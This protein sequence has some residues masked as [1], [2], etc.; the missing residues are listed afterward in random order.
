MGLTIFRGIF[1]FRE[2][3]L[4]FAHVMS[5]SLDHKIMYSLSAIYGHWI[6]KQFSSPR[7]APLFFTFIVIVEITIQ[8]IEENAYNGQFSTK[9]Q[10]R[11]QLDRIH[12]PRYYG[13][14]RSS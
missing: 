1:D 13:A 3:S 4:V 8:L 9:E 12:V 14:N 11:T 5:Q 6:Q 7:G 2:A 10:E